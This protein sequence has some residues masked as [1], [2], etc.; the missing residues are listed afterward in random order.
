MR[1]QPPS[2]RLKPG[3]LVCGECGEGNVE[4]RKFCSR[5]GN[6]LALAV[7]VKTPW[8]R[9]LLPRTGAKVRKSGDR[10]KRRGRAGKSKTGLAVSATFKAVRRIIAI[11][12]LVGGIVYG[13]FAPFRGWV[14]QQAASAKHSVEAM[15]FPQYEP[16]RPTKN[17][18]SCPVQVPEN[19]C[20]LVADLGNNTHWATPIDG[21]EPVVEL[22]LDRSVHIARII[23][24]NGAKDDFQGTHRAKKLHL[25]YSTG[26]TADVNLIDNPDPN[27]YDIDNGE[28][29][30]SVEIHVVE[31]F[32]SVKGTNLAITEIELFEKT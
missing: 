8:W 18:V 14:N 22:K 30:S 29:A 13:V 4:T 1:R 20:G 19:P 6:S 11:A 21:R 9:K 24:T 28:G 32:Q 31:V 17:G 10:P 7:K 23:V 15:I 25:V 2:R 3:D 27:T 16:V 26:K 12:L 5:C